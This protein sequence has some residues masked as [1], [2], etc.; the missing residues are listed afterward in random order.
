MATVKIR[1]LEGSFQ[2]TGGLRLFRQGWV[3][4]HGLR[5][6][7]CLVHGIGEHSG[8][9]D[10]LAS[11]LAARRFAVEAF[12]LRGHGHSD[13]LRAYV[14]SFDL[15]LDD[16]QIKL[17]Q[18]RAEYTGVPVFLL[19]HSMGGTI[20]TL[21][22]IR[23]QPNLSGLIVSAPSILPSEEVSP[24]LIRLSSLM[25]TLLPRLPTVKLDTGA[26]SR[27]PEVVRQYDQD[28]LVYHRGVRARTGAEL[29]RAMKEIRENME[30]VR[31]PLLILQGTADRLVEPT[32]SK[33]L[34]K[35]AES[36]DK[37]LHLY[38]GFYH[39]NFNDPDNLRV[40]EDVLAWLEART[41]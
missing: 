9:Y 24:I 15:Y 25:G 11:W 8:R 22:T 18:I 36:E 7:V 37:T 13:G 16:L 34:Y 23:M 35:Q 12:D 28:P 31:L 40:F 39:E 17:D 41:D 38:E 20:V 21:Y 5:A 19:G 27:D 14:H 33:F 2:G 1:H 32:G 30:A 3:P 10:H 4:K 6:V 26:L 29:F